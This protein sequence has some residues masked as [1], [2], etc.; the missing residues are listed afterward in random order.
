M[1]VIVALEVDKVGGVE[2]LGVVLD[3]LLGTTVRAVLVGET[4]FFWPRQTLY[5]DAA[6]SMLPQEAYTQPKA[7]SPNDSPVVL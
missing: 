7:T 5:A 3:M 1:G 4:A 2:E 6:V